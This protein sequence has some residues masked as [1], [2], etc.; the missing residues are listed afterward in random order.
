MLLAPR[1]GHARWRT[2]AHTLASGIDNGALSVESN[3][4]AS[5]RPRRAPWS[6]GP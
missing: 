6:E 3:V 1:T 4:C 2:S 5:V